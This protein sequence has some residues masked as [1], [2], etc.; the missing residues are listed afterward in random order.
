MTNNFNLPVRWRAGWEYC[1][2]PYDLGALHGFEDRGEPGGFRPR[3]SMTRDQR[4]E[5]EDGYREAHSY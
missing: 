1:T 4:E 3:Y 2:T 5:Y